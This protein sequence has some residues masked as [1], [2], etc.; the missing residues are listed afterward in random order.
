[1]KR[2]YFDKIKETLSTDELFDLGWEVAK[3]ESAL[4]IVEHKLPRW[5]EL[6]KQDG[7]NAKHQVLMEIMEAMK[8]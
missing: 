6:L 5:V 8:S 1:M 7:V 2:E 4:K 3:V